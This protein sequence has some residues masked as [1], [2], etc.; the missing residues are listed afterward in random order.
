MELQHRARATCIVARRN[1]AVWPRGFA[2]VIVLIFVAL[3]GALAAGL[4]AMC[5]TSTEVTG[6][7]LRAARAQAAVESGV[8]FHQ[9]HISRAMATIYS[10]PNP[11][12][13]NLW[14][15]AFQKQLAR[16]IEGHNGFAAGTVTLSADAGGTMEI[17]L[18]SLSFGTNTAFSAVIR[19]NAAKTGLVL[20]VD[21][22][23]VDPSDSMQTVHQN[24]EVAITLTAATNG[25][26]SPYPLVSRINILNAVNV[27]RTGARGESYDPIDVPFTDGRFG[28][29]LSY[30]DM[31]EINGPV[32]FPDNDS[33]IAAVHALTLPVAAATL[34]N[35]GNK[36][37]YQVN[38]THGSVRLPVAAAPYLLTGTINGIVYVQWPN[39]VELGG[40][41]TLNG[42][43]VM[44]RGA[45]PANP[46]SPSPS[47]VI[48]R[49][50]GWIQRSITA[51]GIELAAIT[52]NFARQDELKW[53]SILAPDADLDLGNGTVW[54]SSKTFEGSLHIRSFERQG[55]GSDVGFQVQHGSI[56]AE[57]NLNFRSNGA[58]YA[59]N[60]D[61]TSVEGGGPVAGSAATDWS[62]YFEPLQ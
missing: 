54:D 19:P 48:L 45:A 5:Q 36:Q 46:D 27:N 2:A 40:N 58:A 7:Q 24:A 4:Y 62:T 41:V 16:S 26:P 20:H 47:K 15:E 25:S 59:V 21:G 57:G 37:V 9:Y 8:Q 28:Q 35:R 11:T 31:P 44:Q 10:R 43:I 52:P 60:P 3:C 32:P 13:I 22:Q 42:T 55:G 50:D 14:M 6:N 29:A 18:P 49:R 1:R 39:T 34:T 23:T 30:S 12:I 33:I 61:T 51:A 38:G 56:I 17:R 53:Y